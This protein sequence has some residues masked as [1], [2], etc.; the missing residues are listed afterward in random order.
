MSMLILIIVF[1]VVIFIVRALLASEN[2]PQPKQKTVINQQ[3]EDEPINPIPTYPESPYKCFR[4]AGIS[5]YCNF[6]DVGPISGELRK[7]PENRYDRNAVMILEANKEKLLGYIPKDHQ[8]IYKKISE[9]KDRRPFVGFIDTYINEDGR[10][11]LF[12]VIRTYSGE[13]DVVLNDAQNDW[14][15]LHAAFR[16]KSYEKR[17]EVLDQFKY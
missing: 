15:F 12:G 7:E 6:S 3:T 11:C 9:G 2:K 16:I 10:T 14:D 13:D 5:N 4:I 8:S 1:I 17:M